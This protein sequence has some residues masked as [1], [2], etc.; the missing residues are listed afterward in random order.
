MLKSMRAGDAPEVER[1]DFRVVS[2][3]VGE[4][5]DE[6]TLILLLLNAIEQG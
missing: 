2:L 6:K 3:Y 1:K 4:Q 5:V